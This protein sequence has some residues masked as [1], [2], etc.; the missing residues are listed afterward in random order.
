MNPENNAQTKRS[1]AATKYA[2]T[3]DSRPKTSRRRFLEG[4]VGAG[5]VGLLAGCSGGSAGSSTTTITIGYQPFGTPYWSEL[6]VKHGELVEKYTEP[7]EGD[8]EVEWQSALQGSVIGNR[9]IAGKNQAGYNGDMPTILALANT[10]KPI[11]M[12]G[13]SGWSW[14]QQCN[15]VITPKDSD[16]EGPQD[17]DGADVGATTGAC[18]HRFL[19]SLQEYE[20]ISVN[21][22][23]QDVNTILANI[24]SGELDAGVMWE[25]NPTMGVV[26]QDVAD[27][28]VTGAPYDDPDI[29]ALT[30]NDSFMTE[31]RDAA[32]AVM[33]AELE[34]K[35]I[36][37][38]DPERTV[39][40][41]NQEEDL[42]DYEPATIEASL[43]EPIGI[44]PDTPKM[45]FATDLRKIEPAR[46]LL[47]ETAPAFLLEQGAIDQ[48]PTEERY[49]FGLLDEAASDLESEVEW[50]PYDDEVSAE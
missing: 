43:F 41:I 5:A 36:M 8:Y 14:G 33:K 22:V 3:D 17:L 35:H 47:E 21:L 26:Q 15:V 25:P 38:S 39:E 27:W 46:Q 44:N 19:L 34:A 37:K 10:D 50:S 23:D 9:M 6:V 31:N 11:N 18:S 29:G 13:L 48:L 42:A 12:I 24:G 45:E 20:N 30:M 1:E 28:V 7:L 16:I 40:L 49:S 2:G 32:L 4:A